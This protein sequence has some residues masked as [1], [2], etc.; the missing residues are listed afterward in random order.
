MGFRWIFYLNFTTNII[1]QPCFWI[2]CLKTKTTVAT[3]KGKSISIYIT[4]FSYFCLYLRKSLTGQI[5]KIFI[6]ECAGERE[7]L[8][9]ENV[10]VMIFFW[11]VNKFNIN[12]LWKMNGYNVWLLCESKAEWYIIWGFITGLK[13]IFLQYILVPWRYF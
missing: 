6:H 5:S 13:I 8:W 3:T 1:F 10:I 9:I 11:H 2:R 12:V 7:N 4:D